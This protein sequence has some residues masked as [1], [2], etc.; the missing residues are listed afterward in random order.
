MKKYLILLLFPCLLFGAANDVIILKKNSANTANEQVVLADPGA[1]KVIGFNNTSNTVEYFTPG[2]GTVT[3]AS[4]VTANGVSASV[5]NATTT[6]AFTFTLGA[7]TPS[8]MAAT[9][10]VSGTT[11]T[12]TSTTSLLL[13]TAGSAVGNIGFRNATSGTATLAPPTGALGTY[14]VTLPNAASTL[15]IFGQQITFSGP[16]TA[17]TVTFPD[18]SFTAA[19]TDAANTFTGIQTM[20]SPSITTSVD[21]GSTSFTAFAG[22]TTL[23]TIGGTG[24][25][26]SSFFP[27]TLDTSSS[28]TG[29]IRTSGGISAAKAANI[30]TTLTVG[31]S[32]TIGSGASTAGAVSLGQGTTQSTGT[33][34]ITIQAPTSVTSYIR[35][36]PSAVG[37]TGF[38]LETVS[39]SV[40]TESLV[41]G[42]GSANV[43]RSTSPTLDAGAMTLAENAS[44]ALDPAGSADGKYSGITVTGTAGYT[45]SFGDLVYLDPT[46]SRWE[47]A[48]ANSASGADGDSRGMLGMVV[49]AGTD[50]TAC[51][52]LL[53]GII[54]ADAKFPT[55]TINNPIYVS[56]T[57]GSVTQTQPTTTDVVIRILGA[58]LTA[59]E[60]W[61]APDMAWITHT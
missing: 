55:F 23:M 48:D 19:R 14:S 57:A 38:L 58:A 3:T 5:A 43:M 10:A 13:G 7:I 20:T 51:T 61:F 21:T 9:G 27:S 41:A 46:D 52:I 4:V 25:S 37:S 1:D 22:A 28:T 35:T 11:G 26:A 8:S 36:L 50:G 24:A 54:R 30:G 56:E 2:T 12:F 34:N 39:G 44:I 59:D 17:R 53:Q 33:T 32:V 18:A 15:P 60:M 45:Q 42:T 31:T 6:P 49:S 29:A 40:Q 47:A 16:S